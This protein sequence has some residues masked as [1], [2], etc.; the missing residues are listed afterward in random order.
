MSTG[1]SRGTGTYD[2]SQKTFTIHREDID[3]ISGKK[4]KAKEVIKITGKD[5]Y[6]ST[7]YKL[8]GE[9][10]V[11]VMHIFFTRKK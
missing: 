1:I 2:A 6:D 10:E 11:K 5:T 4:T 9:T 7:F 3:P 8:Q